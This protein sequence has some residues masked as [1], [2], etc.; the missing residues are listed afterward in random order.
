M[1]RS[2]R[3]AGWLACLIIAALVGLVVDL[4]GGPD[5]AAFGFAAVVYLAEVKIPS[6]RY[7][8]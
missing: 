2:D 3:I 8:E 7:D 6:R 1:S 4:L 5:W